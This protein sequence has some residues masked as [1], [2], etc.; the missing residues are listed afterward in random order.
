MPKYTYSARDSKGKEVEGKLEARDPEALAEI[1]QDKGL[2]VVNIK[3]QMAVDFEEL[4]QINI[5]GIPMKEKV[6]FMRQLATMVGAGLPLT[7]GLQIMEQQISNPMFR[8]VITQVRI[9]VESG[10]LADSLD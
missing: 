5:G 8:K 9:S 3:E 4:S 1:L 7:R 2:I 10:N 6:I